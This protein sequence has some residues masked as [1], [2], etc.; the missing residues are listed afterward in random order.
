VKKL[1]SNLK[2]LGLFITIFLF[3]LLFAAGSMLYDGFFSCQVFLN[4]LIDNAFLIITAIGMTFVLIIGGIDL[5]VGAVVALTCML[6]AH[7]LEKVHMSPLLVIPLMLVM[8]SFFG[9]V[10]GYLIQNFKMQPFIVTLAGMFMARGLCY[11]ISI[12]TITISDPLYQAIS[13]YRIPLPFDS[14]ISISVVIALVTLLAALYLANYTKFGRTAYAIG[15]NEQSALLM[16]LPVARTKILIY[17]LSGFCSGL[18]G[19][20][21]S[22]YMLSGYGLHCIGL[23]MDA[24]AAAVIGGT[25]L[26]GGV[27]FMTGTLFGVLIQGVIQTL[28]MFQ[29]TLSSWWT[30]IAV[31]FLLC[32]FIILQRVI[33]IKKDSRKVVTNAAPKA[34]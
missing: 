33:M 1:Q 32:V 27:G 4:L 30:R 31:A 26:T 13:Q 9:F 17:T 18:T 3:S 6:S 11:V 10:M 22:F 29:G 5:S 23:E 28:I 24:I 8:G 15:G 2:Y 14:F 12:D 21:F 20:V 16:G 7:L 25:P 34:S 19:I